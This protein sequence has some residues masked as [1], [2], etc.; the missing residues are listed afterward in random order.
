MDRAMEM[1]QDYS[2]E[3]GELDQLRLAGMF[4]MFRESLDLHL[5]AREKKRKE[6]RRERRKAREEEEE[7]KRKEKKK[8][9]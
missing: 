2:H 4:E 5:D 6:E 8:R 7:K 1:A 9:D 3:T